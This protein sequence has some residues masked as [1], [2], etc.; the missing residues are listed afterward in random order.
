MNGRPAGARVERAASTAAEHSAGSSPTADSLPGMSNLSC[1][2]P[3]MADAAPLALSSRSTT[4]ITTKSLRRRRSLRWV[5]KGAW[6][7]SLR[8]YPSNSAQAR[9]ATLA[10]LSRLRPPRRAPAQ[11]GRFPEPAPARDRNRA[12]GTRAV[13][14]V[15]HFRQLHATCGLRGCGPWNQNPAFLH[16]FLRRSRVACNCLKIVV[17]PVRVRVSPY[18]KPGAAWISF[19]RRGSSYRTRIGTRDGSCSHVRVRFARPAWEP[20]ERPSMFSVMS[21]EPRVAVRSASAA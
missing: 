2:R 1:G 6:A 19:F 15:Q 9:V 21:S 18:A 10:K 5:G 20:G 14:R 8:A 16:D 13:F 7:Y 3:A 4:P 12:N 11:P 17:S